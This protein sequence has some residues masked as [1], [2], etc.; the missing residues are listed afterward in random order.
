MARS[1]AGLSEIEVQY[2]VAGCPPR[3]ACGA[4]LVVGGLQ[5]FS[6]RHDGVG[7]DA[8][9]KVSIVHC[10]VVKGYRYSNFTVE[11][12]KHFLSFVKHSLGRR[13]AAQQADHT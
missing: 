5:V 12:S 6:R 7:Y 4:R 9:N 11:C 3:S 2:L 13:T 1:S 8:C 10:N